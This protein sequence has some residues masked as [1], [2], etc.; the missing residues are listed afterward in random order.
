MKF[1]PKASAN[2]FSL[3]CNCLKGKKIKS[4][5]KINIM[6]CS[7][8]DDIILDSFIKTHDSWVAG[9]NFLQEAGQ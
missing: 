9:V 4:G 5:Q 7:S 1:F 6:V 3:T 2:L 8:E